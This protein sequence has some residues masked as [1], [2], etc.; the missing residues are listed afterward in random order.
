MII[1]VKE[2]APQTIGMGELPMNGGRMAVVTERF[3]TKDGREQ[4][5]RTLRQVPETNRPYFWIPSWGHVDRSEMED[6]AA[7]AREKADSPEK[8]EFNAYH[9]M[10]KRKL[11]EMYRDFCDAR[12]AE[13]AGR[14]H[15][16]VQGGTSGSR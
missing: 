9:L 5:R 16:A 3:V 13:R 15:Y 6:L 2:D 8:Q 12:E 11:A 7:A 4:V 14:K 10:R 1:K